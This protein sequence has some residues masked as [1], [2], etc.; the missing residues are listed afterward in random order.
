MTTRPWMSKQW[1][2]VCN[3][4]CYHQAKYC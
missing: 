4:V 1:Q 2:A 3:A